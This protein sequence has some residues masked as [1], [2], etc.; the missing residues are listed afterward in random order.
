MTEDPLEAKVIDIKARIADF[1]LRH[2]W[3]YPKT[4]SQPKPSV[5]VKQPP[6]KDAAEMSDLRKRLLGIS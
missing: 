5:S 2:S 1:K 6:K 3:L 4:T